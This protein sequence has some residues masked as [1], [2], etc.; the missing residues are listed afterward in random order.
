M[1]LG[2]SLFS[3]PWTPQKRTGVLL[4]VGFFAAFVFQHLVHRFFSF[5][6]D[7]YAHFPTFMRHI[8]S[9]DITEGDYYPSEIVHTRD[10]LSEVEKAVGILLLISLE[11]IAYMF[12]YLL[13]KHHFKYLQEAGEMKKILFFALLQSFQSINLSFILKQQV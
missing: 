9:T 1:P 11:G 8:L 4:G 12:G 6:N 10:D 3:A 13:H 2:S 7:N 5:Y